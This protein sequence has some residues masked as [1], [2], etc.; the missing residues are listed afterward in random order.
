[1]S[2]NFSVVVFF[3][4]LKFSSIPEGNKI[5]TCY[6]RNDYARKEQEK[7]LIDVTQTKN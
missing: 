2:V 5:I 6:Y 1:M 4:G 7:E 3:T